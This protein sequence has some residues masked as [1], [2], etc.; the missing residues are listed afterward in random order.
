MTTAVPACLMPFADWQVWVAWNAESRGGTVRKVPHNPRTGGF[1]SVSDPGTW[2][3]LAAARRL[4]GARGFLVLG[5]YPPVC[6][7]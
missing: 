3:T 2:G 1:A 6:R 4:A 7:G 5:S